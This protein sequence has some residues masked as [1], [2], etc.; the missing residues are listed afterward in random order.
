MPV[1]VL[2]A[3]GSAAG[4]PHVDG[5]VEPD[6]LRVPQ[7]GRARLRLVELSGGKFKGYIYIYVHEGWM[8]DGRTLVFGSRHVCVY[9]RIVLYI[10]IGMFFCS[11]FVSE[12]GVVL[13]GR[14]CALVGACAR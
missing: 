10:D 5:D 13:L 1:A 4:D 7:G 3:G 11:G 8:E 9:V 14:F 2:G 6:E 12:A